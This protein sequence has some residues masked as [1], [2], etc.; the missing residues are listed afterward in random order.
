MI[1]TNNLS[2]EATKKV[3]DLDKSFIGTSDYMGC[4]YFWAYEYRHYLRD[5]SYAVRRKVHKQF[6]K[7][8]LLVDGE[9]DQH[10][11]IIRKIT[12]LY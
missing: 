6:L 7:C 11:E 3:L 1:N 9:S 2:I 5:V 12:K 8:F 10:L 4:A